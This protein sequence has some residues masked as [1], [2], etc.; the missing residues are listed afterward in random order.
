MAEP[1]ATT[2]TRPTT[3]DAVA[4]VLEAS[5]A[6]AAFGVISVQD[7]AILDAIGRRR[8]IRF[9]PARGEA[10]AVNMAD[11]HARVRDALGVAVTSTGTGC[12]NAAGALRLAEMGI[13]IV[14]SVRGRL[15]YA[16]EEFVQGDAA[17]ILG[18]AADR[19][20]GGPGNAFRPDPVFAADLRRARA[21]A[22]DRLRSAIA[23][24]RR[25]RG[26]ARRASPSA[27]RWAAAAED[28]RDARANVRGR[29]SPS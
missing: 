23:P 4:A 12:G 24:L 3:G 18:G 10:E 19:L 1:G 6:T 9:V 22:E 13:G 29:R 8:R 21:G 15:A 25:A 11:G 16:A 5:G 27:A 17:A 7:M 20:D 14:T 26:R 2:E 28:W